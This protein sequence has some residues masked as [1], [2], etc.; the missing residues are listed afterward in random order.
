MNTST[1]EGRKA[2]SVKDAVRNARKIKG[3]TQKQAA[4]A[5]GISVAQYKRYES[6]TS[7]P[8]KDAL[9]KLA[10]GLGISTDEIVLDYGERS[11]KEEL[12]AMFR[13]IE[14][15][16]EE[17]QRL[18]KTAIRNTLLGIRMEQLR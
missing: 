10:K 7:E 9:V 13:Q 4:E 12:R 6:G 5:C 11:V 15:L 1:D 3:L 18:V 14:G 2:V 17:E 16:T 8:R